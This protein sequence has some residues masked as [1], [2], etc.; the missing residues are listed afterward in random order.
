MILV[1]RITCI[2]VNESILNM[3][4]FNTFDTETGI[5]RAN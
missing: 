3:V 2:L 5:F 4:T 1:A